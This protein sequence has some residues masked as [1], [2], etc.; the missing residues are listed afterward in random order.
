MNWITTE[1]LIL[2]P[3]DPAD[4]T[5]EYVDWLNDPEVNRFLEVRHQVQTLDTCRDFVRSANRAP[6]EHLFAIRHASDD[7]HI[8]NAKLGSV[9]AI[10][11]RGQVSLFI[12]NRNYW[13]RGLAEE[14]VMALS[15]YGF[16]QLG[17]NRLEAGCY[18]DN[19][20]SLR[21]FQKCGYNVDGFFRNH[22]LD[23]DDYRGVF[24]LG[25]LQGE[26][27]TDAQAW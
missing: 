15:R 10:H 17:L 27:R 11:A 2:H 12:G 22:V 20:A 6:G 25:L 14:I 3:L 13:G 26:F 8:G 1:N 23:G 24:W 18:E 4:V 5:Q 16:E 19:L 7:R 21:V 9:N